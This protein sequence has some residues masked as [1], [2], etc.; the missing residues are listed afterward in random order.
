MSSI[1]EWNNPCHLDF[2][3]YDENGDIV[4]Y[5]GYPVSGYV[6]C[7]KHGFYPRYYGEGWEI[8]CCCPKC[9]EEELL[10]KKL[11]GA[12]I[13]KRFLNHSLETFETAEQWQLKAL[14]SVK[15]YSDDLDRNLSEGR[16]IVMI[17]NPGTGKTNLVIDVA[18]SVI[19]RAGTA[20]YVTVSDLILRVRDSW[21]TGKT[22]QLIDNFVGVDLLILDEVGVQA[23]TQNEQ[24]IIFDVINKRYAEMKPTIILT[25]LNVDRCKN[26]LGE[27]VWDRLKENDGLLITFKGSSYRSM[28]HAVKTTHQVRKMQIPEW[29]EESHRDEKVAA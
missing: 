16:C 14:D 5:R 26:F 19:D 12:A 17:G 7:P 2:F 13:P 23:G 29:H 10:A 28:A 15:S 18:R 11:A 27:R 21:G 24:N 22:L 4:G 6:E 9:L 3:E 25:N 1:H 8:R 20:C